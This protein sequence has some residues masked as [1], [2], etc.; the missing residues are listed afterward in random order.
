[1][2]GMYLAYA[3]LIVALG[4]LVIVMGCTGGGGNGA[5]IGPSPATNTVSCG[6]G[7]NTFTVSTGTSDGKC[8]TNHPGGNVTGGECV[9]GSNSAQVD[10]SL[11]GGKGACLGSTGSGSCTAK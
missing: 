10:C 8:T 1:M 7:G 4:L 9:S 5:G 3:L 6:A 11:N 2:K